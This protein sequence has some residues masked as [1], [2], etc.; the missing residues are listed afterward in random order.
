M[1]AVTTTPTAQAEARKTLPSFLGLIRGE[2]F[3]I[4]HQFTTWL[5]FA[6]VLGVNAFFWM[7]LASSIKNNGADPLSFIRNTEG[8]LALLR[9][10]GGL[11]LIVVTVRIVGLDFQQG[12][13]RIILGR[14]VARLQ[15]LAAKFIA[16]LIAGTVLLVTGLALDA[17][18]GYITYHTFGNEA[19]SAVV[20]AHYWVDMRLYVFTI[21]V[22]MVVTI[23]M[24]IA[25]T[26]FGRSMTFGLSVGLI[27]FAADN[28]GTIVMR[29][30]TNLTNSSFWNDLTG[31]FLGP[32]LNLMPSV[33]L[34][35]RLALITDEKG[36]S[37]L[38]P[39]PATSIGFTPGGTFDA[40]HTL[41][42]ALVYGLIFIA[43]AT[44]LTWRRDVLE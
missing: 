37:F 39:D 41:V 11:A 10:F 9:A 7:A 15:L 3:K 8:S 36:V 42:V 1:S 38:A 30:L 20:N 32:N 25:A 33:L 16:A 24:A 13:I 34:A 12:T 21:V 5:L 40:T 23:L 31:Y 17:L 26:V 2:L 4:T 6:L 43:I 18:G 29:L 44:I 14:G 19:V 35:P 27:F 28:I 22:S